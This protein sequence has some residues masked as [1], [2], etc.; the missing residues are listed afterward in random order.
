MK[1]EENIFTSENF[2][3]T[4]FNC[5]NVQIF[6]INYIKALKS[7][8]F[9]LFGDG[10]QAVS[11]QLRSW[12]MTFKLGY[13]IPYYHLER[14]SKIEDLNSNCFL[15][16]ITKNI[17]ISIL[18]QTSVFIP[19]LVVYLE[20]HKCVKPNFLSNLDHLDMSFDFLKT[21]GFLNVFLNL[22]TLAREMKILAFK[23]KTREISKRNHTFLITLNS[24]K[25]TKYEET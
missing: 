23:L 2:L 7:F 14:D 24:H 17:V 4:L 8:I 1:D 18:A 25:E 20:A 12:P 3:I 19:I 15:K 10:L 5:K 21:K 11:R 22:E 9:S 13:S 6:T 16:V